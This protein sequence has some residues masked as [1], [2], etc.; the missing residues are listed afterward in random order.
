MTRKIVAVVAG[1]V[2]AFGWV[3]LLEAIGHAWYPPPAGLDFH[4]PEHLKVY[5]ATVPLA[6]LWWILGAWFVATFAGG[7]LA[8]FIARESPA[9][10]AS[11]VGA[12]VLAVM[13]AK[14]VVIPHPVWFSITA[15]VA[16]PLA[17]AAAGAMGNAF[18]RTR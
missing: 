5:A 1:T 12:L 16:I 18:S 6:A 10:F 15:I 13:I 17:A 2:V 3:A 7:W 8:A 9:H 4:N 11:I 14:L